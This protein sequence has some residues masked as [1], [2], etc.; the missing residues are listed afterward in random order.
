MAEGLGVA[1]SRLRSIVMIVHDGQ[2]VAGQNPKWL[3]IDTSVV[4]HPKRLITTAVII[5]A[6]VSPLQTLLAHA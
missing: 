5:A 4:I 6:L 2:T 3:Q 1:G